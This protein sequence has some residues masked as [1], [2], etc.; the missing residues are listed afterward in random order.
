MLPAYM[1]QR[2]ADFFEDFDSEI[3]NDCDTAVQNLKQRL[4]LNELEKC[5]DGFES[6]DGSPCR[7][8]PKG[9]FGKECLHICSCNID[10]CDHVTGC[11]NVL[12]STEA[13]TTG[14]HA[15][16]T[17]FSA[18]EPTTATKSNT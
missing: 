6:L 14:D 9:Y 4:C 1:R 3:Q 2:A 15:E 13:A 5:L 7:S 18:L 16:G 10:I 8:C 12:P 17:F 11:L